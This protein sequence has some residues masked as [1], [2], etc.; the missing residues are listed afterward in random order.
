VRVLAP[1]HGVNV[2]AVLWLAFET[3]NLAWPRPSPA[4]LGAP[5]YQPWA[6]PMVVAAITLIGLVYF[7]VARPHGR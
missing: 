2:L 7:V 1:W 5:W 6:A 3:V 4:P